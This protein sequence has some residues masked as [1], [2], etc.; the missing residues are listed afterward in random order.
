MAKPPSLVDLR[1]K[2]SSEPLSYYAIARATGYHVS[3]I[4]RVFNGE[5]RPSID[6]LTAVSGYLGCSVDKLIAAL[7]AVRKR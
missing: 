4:T 6:C 2:G 7:Q 5:R 1:K 3:Y